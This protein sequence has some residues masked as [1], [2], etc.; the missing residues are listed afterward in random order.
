[1]DNYDIV[2]DLIEHPERY[3]PQQ[4]TEILADPEAREIY[5]LI[6]KS[7][8]SLK[9]DGAK[10]DVDAEWESFATQNFRPRFR[11]LR[12]RNRAASIAVIVLSSVTALAVGLAV[13]V[14]L[15]ESG[16]EPE[17]AEDV[18]APSTVVA[19][20]DTVAVPNDS[21]RQAPSPV[22]FENEALAVIL[23]SVAKWHGVSVSYRTPDVADL[24]LYYKFDP[25]QPLSEIV[26]QL[27]TFEQINI[28]LDG[29]TLIVD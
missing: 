29:K 22:L 28:R 12:F 21:V 4:M 1:M 20:A 15:S 25:A 17:M 16:R 27:N 18:T 6:C 13:T 26:E 11:L 14:N 7:E 9:A 3:T 10:A 19:V 5:N 2:L 24:H 8:S 23:D